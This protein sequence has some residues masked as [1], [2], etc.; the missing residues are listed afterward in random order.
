MEER[1]RYNEISYFFRAYAHEDMKDV[2][3]EIEDAA[4][5]YAIEQGSAKK[6]RQCLQDVLGL[7]ESDLSE[8]DLE[9][10]LLSLGANQHFSKKQ[11]VA[12][13]IY[14]E[15]ECIGAILS[16]EFPNH[17]ISSFLSRMLSIEV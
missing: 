3:G 11:Y 2:H 13:S 6:V 14:V 16:V 5:D 17:S 10:C 9:Q 8:K 12:G 4:R 7:L 15:S 1:S